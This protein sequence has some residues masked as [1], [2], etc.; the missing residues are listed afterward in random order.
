VTAA[1]AVWSVATGRIQQSR[2]GGYIERG[3]K[4][5]RIQRVIV[6]ENIEKDRVE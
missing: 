1:G 5:G 2:V 3:V 4:Y 6:E